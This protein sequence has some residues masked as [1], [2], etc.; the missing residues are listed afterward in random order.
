MKRYTPIDVARAIR[1]CEVHAS[2]LHHRQVDDPDVT[3]ADLG[4]DRHVGGLAEAA[5]GHAAHVLDRDD[6][7][8]SMR[9]Q[10][11]EAAQQLREGWLP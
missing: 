2:A 9:E 4:Y 1:V 5:M 8:F 11:A 3:A 10:D 7:V 6:R